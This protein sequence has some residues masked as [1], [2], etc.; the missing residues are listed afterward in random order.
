L[1]RYLDGAQTSTRR[2][3][4]LTQRLLAFSRRQT[5][6]PRPTDINKLIYGIDE[7]I[8]R[9]VGPA[10]DVEV[11]GQH[12]LWPARVDAAQLESALI[13]LAINA[14]DAMPEG[15]RITIETANK[16][17]D[18]RAAL[19]RELTPGQYLSICVTDTGAGISK[20]IVER[21]F[22]PFFTTKPIGEG[23]GLGLSMVHGFVRQSG[24]Q[25]RV[26]SEFGE[27][28]TMCLYLPRYVG[29]VPADVAK[30][31]VIPEY[32]SGE[33]VLIVD[34]EP[35]VRMLMSDVLA[36]AGYAVLDAQDGPAAVRI[37]Q[38]DKRIDLLI[39]DVGLPGGMN[40]RQVADAARSTRP[41]LKVLF[42]T[43]FAENAA[44]GNGHLPPGMEVITKPF[45]VAD[46]ATKV[47]EIIES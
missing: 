7:L 42:V 33:T 35:T 21:I 29:E 38:S 3:A 11:V 16:W 15:G 22:D 12:G 44:V 24:G 10:I 41:G 31:P 28:T 19:E 9:T 6:D 2:A 39:T 30:S 1:E 40:G 23:T 43:G 36:E 25:V 18:E 34:D 13:N 26:Y 45:Q 46:L 37:L 17:L 47:S 8:R 5:L 32:G 27:G 14:R 20:E 4:A